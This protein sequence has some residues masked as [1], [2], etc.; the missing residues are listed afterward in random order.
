MKL[1]EKGVKEKVEEILTVNGC[2]DAEVESVSLPEDEWSAMGVELYG[3]LV[4]LKA[5]AEIG[6]EWGDEN[7]SLCGG[8]LKS[9]R[10]MVYLVPGK[11]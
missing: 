9:D 5:L 7:P 2:V 8:Y 6:A 10:L 11:K 4:T 3:G 1:T